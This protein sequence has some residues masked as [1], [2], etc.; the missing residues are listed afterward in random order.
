MRTSRGARS[1]RSQ[2]LI[3]QGVVA[4]RDGRIAWG[5]TR[6]LDGFSEGNSGLL[7]RKSGDRITLFVGAR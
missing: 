3:R 4:N 2:N 1:S 7:V 5:H 6:G